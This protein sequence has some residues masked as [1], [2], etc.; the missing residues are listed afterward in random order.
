MP[1][2]VGRRYLLVTSVQNVSCVTCP[3][4]ADCPARRCLHGLQGR[5]PNV[6]LPGCPPESQRYPFK[7]FTPIPAQRATE[8][9]Q[10]AKSLAHEPTSEGRRGVRFLPH[11][12]DRGFLPVAVFRTTVSGGA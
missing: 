8:G 1:F 9:L 10:G 4:T 5:N 7:G 11:G 6:S 2:P 3:D 12:R